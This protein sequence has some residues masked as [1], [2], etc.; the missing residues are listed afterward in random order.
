MVAV[1]GGCSREDS[2]PPPVETA[3]V[4]S[5]GVAFP[6]SARAGDD[7]VNQ[8]VRTAIESCINGE[9]E[10]FRALWS[11]VE[12]PLDREQFDRGWRT[13]QRISIH[14]IRPMR[15]P[16]DG[17]ILYYVHAIVELAP[18]IRKPKRDVVLLIVRENDAWRLARAPKALVE[19][20]LGN[21]THDSE[22]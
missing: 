14:E 9:Y 1:A 6:D 4:R 17:G 15:R 16:N 2:A 11:A 12:E 5:V 21:K 19:K 3:P 7:E 22:S 10:Q 13:A 20:V 18:E 8:F